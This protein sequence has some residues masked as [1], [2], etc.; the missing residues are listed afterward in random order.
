MMRL[1]FYKSSI[2]ATIVVIRAEGKGT[3]VVTVLYHGFTTSFN[4]TVEKEVD[5][6]RLEKEFLQRSGVEVADNAVYQLHS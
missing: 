6:D 5:L 4:V 2:T 3:A 1:F